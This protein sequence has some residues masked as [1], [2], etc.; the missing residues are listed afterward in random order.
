VVG[1][2]QKSHEARSELN[3]AFRLEKEDGL[4]PIRTSAIESRKY[5]GCAMTFK[6]IILSQQ[7]NRI[8]GSN[9]RAIY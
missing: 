9:V 3:S 8:Y 5:E 6:A 7:D 1:K 4:N 2:G